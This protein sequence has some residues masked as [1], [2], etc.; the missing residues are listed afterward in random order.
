MAWISELE[1]SKE[2]GRKKAKSWDG[3]RLRSAC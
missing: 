2:E 1:E 3:N